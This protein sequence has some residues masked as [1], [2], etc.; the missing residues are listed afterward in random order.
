M[1]YIHMFIHAEF[2]IIN[3]LLK[4]RRSKYKPTYALSYS[5]IFPRCKWTHRKWKDMN[6]YSFNL[7][8]CLIHLS[9]LRLF[10]VCFGILFVSLNTKCS[11]FFMFIRRDLKK[12]L[13]MWMWFNVPDT[14]WSTRVWP[15]CF[16][17]RPGAGALQ[18]VAGAGS[19]SHRQHG[20]VLQP[21]LRQSESTFIW[22]LEVDLESFNSVH[23]IQANVTNY[24]LP[25][26]GFSTWTHTTSLTFDLSHRIR[27]NSQEI[28]KTFT[29]KKVKN[30]SGE[31]QRRT[32]PPPLQ[33]GENNIRHVYNTCNSSP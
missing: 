17:H 4:E 33:D 13:V 31:Q 26:E 16:R 7:N 8:Y 15:P 19:V 21:A 25:S 20:H 12:C 24:K 1:C 10:T 30:P 14:H 3:M 27:K 22:P 9:H 11:H 32:P 18:R 2:K 28:E 6:V 23:F 29:G 5:H